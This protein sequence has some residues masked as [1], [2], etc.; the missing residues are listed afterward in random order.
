MLSSNRDQ[1]TKKQGNKGIAKSG[2]TKEVA[3]PTYIYR[4]C[5]PYGYGLKSRCPLVYLQVQATSLVLQLLSCALVYLL[6][7][8]WSLLNFYY[9]FKDYLSV[10]CADISSAGKLTVLDVYISLQEE[11]KLLVDAIIKD[12]IEVVTRLSNDGVNMDVIIHEVCRP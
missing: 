6:F 2:E 12:N 1:W 3:V 10:F 11:C 4:I 5:N 9:L 7:V 8:F